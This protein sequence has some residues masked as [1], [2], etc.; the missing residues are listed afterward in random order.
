MDKDLEEIEK[1]Y[2]VLAS[3][4]AKTFIN[5]HQNKPKDH[6]ILKRFSQ[7]LNNRKPVWDFGCGIGNTTKYLKDLGLNISGLDLSEEM[8]YQAR[9]IHP[10]ICFK[11]GNIL[12]LNFKN[13]S[14]AGI[15]SFYAIIHFTKEKVLK[16]ISEIFRVLKPNGI[17]L[18][19]H[20]LGDK[21]IHLD[22][23][24]G[25][26]VNLDFMLFTS[27]FITNCLIE[28]GFHNIEQIE[29]EP[30]PSVEYES[31][32]AYTFAIKPSL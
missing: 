32:R 9:L 24:L 13:N 14:I 18:L 19:T 3:E 11:K 5:E 31:R 25:K 20:H 15:V 21:S 30:Y 26:R 7:M 4:W 12:E 16:A 1:I 22:E 6:E 27:D 17:V 23:F 10:N 29:R 28:C 8:L 2:N